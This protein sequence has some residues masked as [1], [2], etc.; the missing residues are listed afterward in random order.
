MCV[1]QLVLQVDVA[2]AQLAKY[3]E[4]LAHW[5][6]IDQD[7][8]SGPQTAVGSQL[9]IQ[10]D[11]AYLSSMMDTD[12]DGVLS[13]AEIAAGKSSAHGLPSLRVPQEDGWLA[14]F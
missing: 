10:M 11:P 5:T 14:A 12:G 2:Q 13:P 9:E 1:A 8:P 7:L 3:S 6:R 4:Q